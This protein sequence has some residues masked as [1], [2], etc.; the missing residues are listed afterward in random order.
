MCVFLV[1]FLFC[2]QTAAPGKNSGIFPEISKDDLIAFLHAPT[3]QLLSDKDG[4]CT[5]CDH[6]L[7]DTHLITFEF[8]ELFDD[9]CYLSIDG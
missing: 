6:T 8:S 9:L 3:I 4:I 2:P 7:D 5:Y 1:R